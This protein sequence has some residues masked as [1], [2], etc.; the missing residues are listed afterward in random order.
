VSVGSLRGVIEVRGRFHRSVRLNRDWREQSDLSSYL[1]IP[2][3]WELAT[4]M[5]QALAEPGGSR[6]RARAKDER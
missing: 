4:R 3:A 1:L 2:T 5:T 6:I